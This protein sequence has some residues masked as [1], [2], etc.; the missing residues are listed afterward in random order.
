MKRKLE[1]A[2][3]CVALFGAGSAWTILPFRVSAT[4]EAVAVLRRDSSRDRE[5]LV[6]IEERL[7]NVQNE[8]K[9]R[10]FP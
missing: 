8:L 1:V 9:K 7:I 10:D 2:A 5:L 3:L 6:R 4:E